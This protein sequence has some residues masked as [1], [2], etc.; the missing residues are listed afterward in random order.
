MEGF[1]QPIQEDKKPSTQKIA[2][3]SEEYLQHQEANEF[4][5]RTLANSRCFGFHELESVYS[6]RKMAKPT[7]ERLSS[8]DPKIREQYREHIE[9]TRITVEEA[10]L[11]IH[12]IITKNI[13]HFKKV[14]TES[15]SIPSINNFISEIINQPKLRDMIANEGRSLSRKTI[16]KYKKLRLS[17]PL[18]D[19]KFNDIKEVDQL[20]ALIGSE[21]ISD[22]L[23]ITIL[24]YHKA[25]FEYRVNK[26]VESMLPELTEKFRVAIDGA[27]DRGELP[28]DKD[29]VKDRM[30]HVHVTLI[31]ALY[32]SLENIGGRFRSN[33]N[34]V[35][36][37][38]FLTSNK[39]RKN[40]LEHVF[41]QEM[42]HVL[43]VR[44]ITNGPGTKARSGTIHHER[45]GLRFHIDR[46]NHRLFSRFFWLNEAVTT[47]LQDKYVPTVDG[48]HIPAKGYVL[49]RALLD[50]IMTNGK[51]PID[52][53]YFVD[54]YFENLDPAIVSKDRLP[55]WK[56][57]VEQISLA[58]EKG[59]LNKVDDYVKKNGIPKTI[60][61]LRSGNLSTD[62]SHSDIPE[63]DEEES[64]LK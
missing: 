49:E 17:H 21:K 63:T 45:V 54:A 3:G 58:W 8:F 27:I 48:Q 18:Y 52:V 20:T 56:S 5:N 7:E 9:N 39:N 59:F 4:R 6:L 2:E 34:S 47:K 29:L 38:S 25:V 41:F 31:D 12:D 60:E 23:W 19:K 14:V 13:K 55:A 36:L 30:E 33:D 22:A 15:K 11:Q 10:T 24:R 1:T 37:D 51:V 26:F 62:G 40:R 35:V 57:L 64:K 32:A 43:S 50:V 42:F 28:L 53:K 44:L 61:D 46:E 16:S